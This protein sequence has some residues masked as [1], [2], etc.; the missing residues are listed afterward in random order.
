MTERSEAHPRIEKLIVERWSPRSFDRSEIPV[1]DLE[2]IFEA[3]GWAPSG[4]NIQ[5]WRFVYA[6]RGDADWDRFLSPLVEFNQ[7][8]TRNASAVIYAVSDTMNRHGSE[9]KP[10]PTHSF[11]TGAAWAM[12]ALQ[13]QAMGYHTH[14]M[15]GLDVERAASE[16][17]VPSDHRVEAAIAIGRQAP[18]EDL[19]EALRE[20][21]VASGRNPVSQFAFAGGFPAN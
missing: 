1:E 11:D 6:R 14:G 10:N 5:P 9:P 2:V 16:L 17:G 20:R 12:L 21:E 7:L 18:R 15:I 19:P 13:A 8:W 4:Y 3:A